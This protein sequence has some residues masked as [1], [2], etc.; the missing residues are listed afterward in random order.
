MGEIADDMIEGNCCPQCMEYYDGEGYGFPT[1]CS[2]SCAKAGG[3]P[4][5]A[6]R[7]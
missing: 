4:D 1:Y 3:Q 2:K 7:E 5:G 6:I